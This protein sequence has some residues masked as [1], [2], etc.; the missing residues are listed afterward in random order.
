MEEEAATEELLQ[1]QA[2]E[3]SS[4][5]L[6]S[7]QESAAEGQ[8]NQQQE[9][10]ALIGATETSSTAK[11][12]SVD[13]G[14]HRPLL[15]AA[16]GV[17]PSI[18]SRDRPGAVEGLSFEA[19]SAATAGSESAEV[20]LEDDSNDEDQEEGSTSAFD[21]AERKWKAYITEQTSPMADFFAGQVR[22]RGGSS[23]ASS[24]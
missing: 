22:S 4:E 5:D 10:Y 7:S 6:L 14:T 13:R 19:L 16:S 1:L 2:D 17:P 21:L 12:P 18:L 8:N 23:L 11:A 24:G 9:H 3:L 15:P 20:G